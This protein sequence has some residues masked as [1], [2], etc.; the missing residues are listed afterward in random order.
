MKYLSWVR[1]RVGRLLIIVIAL[2]VYF[3]LLDIGELRFFPSS[4]VNAA[5]LASF[6]FHLGFSVL[7]S[8]MFLVVGSLVWL[9]ARDRR[10]ALLLFCFSFTAMMIFTLEAGSVKND[11]VFSILGGVASSFA[12][13]FLAIFLL[14]FPR[15]YM[16]RLLSRENRH[17]QPV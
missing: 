14:L 9:F 1:F 12:L 3:F 13:A 5:S 7:I 15:D 11:V 10:V 2:V 17:L 16:S 8:L 4:N 6:W